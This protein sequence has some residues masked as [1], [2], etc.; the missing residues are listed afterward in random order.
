MSL[1]FKKRRDAENSSSWDR[2]VLASQ[3]DENGP[4]I[5]TWEVIC[6]SLVWVITTIMPYINGQQ[7]MVRS[8]HNCTK[9]WIPRWLRRLQPEYIQ[10]IHYPWRVNQVLD[11]II[12]L[13]VTSQNG[14]GEKAPLE[15]DIPTFVGLIQMRTGTCGIHETFSPNFFGPY[16]PGGRLRPVEEPANTSWKR[17]H[18]TWNKSKSMWTLWTP[19]AFE[20]P[21][22]P[23]WKMWKL[24]HTQP[25]PLTS[26]LN[27]IKS[28]SSL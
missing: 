9:E 16:D 22:N 2:G 4:K 7:F 14:E 17:K 27:Y 26:P 13:L 8:Y 18:C 12:S 3:I 10:F 21:S 20:A 23:S 6:H 5:V 1:S 24:L 25:Q 28:S 19:G 15:D 11:A